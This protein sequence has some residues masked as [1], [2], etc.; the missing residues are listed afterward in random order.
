[1]SCEPCVDYYFP[2]SNFLLLLYTKI[3]ASL[4]LQMGKNIFGDIIYTELAGLSAYLLW[5]ES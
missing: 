2:F 3:H 5:G 1:V 4:L